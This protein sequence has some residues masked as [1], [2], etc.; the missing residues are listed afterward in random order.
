MWQPPGCVGQA[1]GCLPKVK[2][3]AGQGCRSGAVPGP[4]CREAGATVRCHAFRDVSVVSAPDERAIEVLASGLP[5]HHGAQLVV[6]VTMSCA[7]TA[8][9]FASPGSAHIR[10]AALLRARRDHELSSLCTGFRGSRDR[11]SEVVDFVSS[12][13]GGRARNAPPLLRW[14][15]FLA[16]RRRWSRMFAVSCGRAFDSSLVTSC[17]VTLDGQDGPPPDLADLLA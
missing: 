14:S 7:L 5:I 2:S 6:D 15:S 17:S 10:G 4:C 11:S 3:V 9:G 12:L 16:W 8:Q 13:A 1:Q